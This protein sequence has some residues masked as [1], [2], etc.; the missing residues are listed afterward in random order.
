ML[1]ADVRA[2][3]SV[4]PVSARPASHWYTAR[5]FVARNRVTVLVA[6]LG[7]VGLVVDM[8]MDMGLGLGVALHQMRA[9][10]VARQLAERRFQQVRQMAGSLAWRAG[11]P[12]Q[13]LR[14]AEASAELMR[15]APLGDNN[16]ARRWALAQAMGEQAAAWNS[17]GRT[18][19]AKVL[20]K[21]ALTQ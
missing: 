8:D 17:L 12:T 7:V 9:S 4:H 3:L 11:D 13:A 1:A 14:W 15:P 5:R 19:E 6:A 16:A 20:A 2:F 21:R 10:D 18:E